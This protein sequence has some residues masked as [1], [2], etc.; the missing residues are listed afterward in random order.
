MKT[1]LKRYQVAAGKCSCVCL[2][3]QNAGLGRQAPT[4]RIKEAARDFAK[5]LKLWRVFRACCHERGIYLIHILITS[6]S[7]IDETEHFGDKTIF[8]IYSPE[9]YNL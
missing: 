8:D 9:T 4:L 2:P 3:S 7:L 5:T 6:E 1:E